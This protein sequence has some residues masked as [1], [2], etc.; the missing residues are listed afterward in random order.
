MI[1]DLMAYGALAL[2]AVVRHVA[3]APNGE[4]VPGAEPT[5]GDGGAR[6]PPAGGV[7]GG[8]EADRDALLERLNLQFD[9]LPIPCLV[10]GPDLTIRE[11]NP[12]AERV[13]GFTRDEAV[14]RVPYGLIVRESLRPLLEPFLTEVAKADRTIEVAVN[15]N[16]TKDGRVIECEWH[17][18]PLRDPRGAL[19]GF[20]AVAQDV[21]AR[22][23]NE[24]Q[25]RQLSRAVEQSPAS[26]IVMDTEGRIEYV[27][28][29]FTEVSGYTR[30]ESV[31]RDLRSFQS[32]LLEP[33]EY[34]VLWRTLEAGRTWQG[35][36]QNRKKNGARYS[37]KVTIAPIRDSANRI[38]H[39]VAVNEDLTER[40]RA[41]AQLDATR[42]E[43]TQAQKLEAVGRLAGGIAHDFN[44]LLTTVLGYTD[45]LLERHP[46]GDP[47][48]DDLEEIRR[49][50]ERAAHLTEQLLAFG[51]Q[52]ILA[53]RVVD[54]N[55]A[56]AGAARLLGT[57]L[58]PGIDLVTH[59]AGELGFVVAD[60]GCLDQI[61]MNLAANARDAMPGG[62]RLTIETR[63]VD[64]TA[65]DEPAHPGV[66][67]GAYVCLSLSDTGKGMSAEVRARVFE[68][69]F[70]TKALGRGTGLG[71]STVYG[72]V[73]QSGGHVEVDSV[74]GDGATFR[75]YLPR[76]PRDHAGAVAAAPPAAI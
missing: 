66:P 23:R 75:V 27:N 58:G 36:L 2:L 49:A 18:T 40:Q 46:P 52:Q 55:A 45:F 26:I 10:I 14:G 33:E 44:N 1:L 5:D 70:T 29:T 32:G 67:P 51:R 15:E 65:D 53:P 25:L 22:N 42:R 61:L 74:E 4:R 68:P 56:V 73:K 63:N 34:A 20:I 54:V 28:P 47:E 7:P 21:T 6:R 24:R 50:G 19:I 72:I 17:H 11:W 3:A 38:T 16:L 37:E 39:Y 13:F 30:E 35:F 9:R 64:I 59:Q 60:P 48:R 62:G 71:L 12:A 69:F 43:L 57:L 41:D 76:V 8:P 31:G